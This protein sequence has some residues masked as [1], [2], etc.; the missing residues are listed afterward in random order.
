V[1]KQDVRRLC[2]ANNFL[3]AFLLSIFILFLT[4]VERRIWDQ[5]IIYMVNMASESVSGLFLMSMATIPF[6]FC[7]VDDFQNKYVCQELVRTD[8]KRYVISKCL[9]IYL[10]SFLT[11]VIS[12][13][14]FILF[15][16]VT[17]HEWDNNGYGWVEQYRFIE[18]YS[19][20]EHRRY[21][22][23][24]LLLSAQKGMLGGMLSLFAAFLSLVIRNRMMVMASPVIIAYIL[25]YY[26][27][28]F[29]G[30]QGLNVMGLFD[31][32]YNITEFGENIYF[33]SIL[34]SLVGSFICV[35]GVFFRVRRK[36]RNG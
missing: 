28:V 21:I 29:I 25:K 16:R 19:L 33:R 31:V 27:N 35:I 1:I 11:I 20:L 10:S 22:G 24:Y 9:L 8:L 17:G 23:F 15:L 36:V 3:I 5:N 30:Y 34:V 13:M 4:I 14:G 26:G 7:F 18:L 32:M 6:S 12:I 2:H